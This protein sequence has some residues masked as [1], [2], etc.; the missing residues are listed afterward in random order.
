MGLVAL[1]IAA[2]LP[3]PSLTAVLPAFNPANFVNGA[4]V[5]NPYFPLIPGSMWVYEGEEED[6]G[7]VISLRIEST[8]QYYRR[9]VLGFDAVVV[10]V[11]DIE[12]GEVK[13][14][15]FDYYL[16]DIFGNVWY[17]G[18]DVTEFDDDGNP[19][20][21][22]GAW[23]A[24][25]NGALPGF[26]MPVDKTVGFN[27]FQEFAPGI[28]LDEGTTFA[29]GGILDIDFG[30][31]MDALQVLETNSLNP[32]DMEFKHYVPGY[33]L[34]LIEEG[35][36]ENLEEPSAILELVSFKIP[37]PGSLAILIAGLGLIGLRRR[38]GGRSF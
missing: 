18:E 21:G 23:I 25:E 9:S 36:D 20:P 16:Q 35:L 12:D 13:E 14:E 10:R 24:G 30:L 5:D 26:I 38:K 17:V 11:R 34:A 6:D 27:Y 37:A 19:F 29:F 32:D 28:A 4:P 8:V 2:L 1:A 22:S 15:T 33:G 31:F 3:N 7:E